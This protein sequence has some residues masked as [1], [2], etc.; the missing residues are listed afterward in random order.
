[1][2]CKVL[3]SNNKTN[4]RYNVL[5]IVHEICL[6]YISL[7]HEIYLLKEWYIHALYIV[8]AGYNLVLFMI[9]T[10]FV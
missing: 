6:E 9:D 5:T 10:Y 8:Y 3:T 4:I 1:M 7:I 2:L